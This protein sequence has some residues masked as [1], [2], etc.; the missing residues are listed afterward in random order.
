MG[1]WKDVWY[2]MQRGMSREVAEEVNATLRYS[3]DE[4]ERKKARIK[5]E[6]DIKLNTLK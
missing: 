1:Y 6:T 3:A 4:Q 5:G 2:D